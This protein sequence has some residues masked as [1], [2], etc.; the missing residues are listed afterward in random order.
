MPQ[1]KISLHKQIEKADALYNQAH[2]DLDNS[3]TLLDVIAAYQTILDEN[4]FSSTA[5]T[6]TKALKNH[7]ELY[8]TLASIYVGAL[9]RKA[10][11]KKLQALREELKV[12]LKT[13]KSLTELQCGD[14]LSVIRDFLRERIN[15]DHEHSDQIDYLEFLVKYY[16]SSHPTVLRLLELTESQGDNKSAV[17][18]KGLESVPDLLAYYEEEDEETFFHIK[19]LKKR[20]IE[21][22]MTLNN[23]S[24][25]EDTSLT[26][27]LTNVDPLVPTAT[28]VVN[29]TS[30]LGHKRARQAETTSFSFKKKLIHRFYTT[31]Q[32]AIS[33]DGNSTATNM[34]TSQA[35]AGES[36]VP[37]GGASSISQS[38]SNSSHLA[39]LSIANEFTS[40]TSV[41]FS[42]KKEFVN[43]LIYVTQ[44]FNANDR[45][46]IQAEILRQIGLAQAKRLQ[47]L[48]GPKLSGET[49]FSIL[50]VLEK[51]ALFLDTAKPS[52]DD[53]KK[54][55]ADALKRIQGCQPHQTEIRVSQYQTQLTAYPDGYFN[56]CLLKFASRV[57]E[58]NPA[59]YIKLLRDII[60]A[61]VNAAEI[62]LLL[63]KLPA[64]Q[65]ENC[66]ERLVE[67]ANMLQSEHESRSTFRL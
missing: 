2:A 62:Q 65:V 17:I 47:E 42:T 49:Y 33:A 31:P 57:A 59:N 34:T 35:T 18:E 27:S 30:S 43:A 25:V 32:L 50:I 7:C 44:S 20:L 51:A 28:P 23:S 39:R 16:H 11:I 24:L 1:T 10:G 22:K 52:L 54:T 8:L 6:R 21:I 38:S 61:I 36:I 56:E 15:L 64:G 26:N 55:Y 45:R 29:E 9:T 13:D 60:C 12:Y 40:T 3:D 4:E 5:S 37:G 19:A 46:A 14:N 67:T 58:N 53:F 41:T 63:E 48:S 66:Q